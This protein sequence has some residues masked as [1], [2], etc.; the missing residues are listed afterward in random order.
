M[1]DDPKTMDIVN[2]ELRGMPQHE[3]KQELNLRTHRAGYTTREGGPIPL[4][5]MT[6]SNWGETKLNNWPRDENGNLVE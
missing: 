6:T 1:L 3:Y 5:I 4:R 2:P